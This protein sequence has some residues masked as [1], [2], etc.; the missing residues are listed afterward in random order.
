[1]GALRSL[2]RMI[3]F[4]LPFRQCKWYATIG[5]E[6]SDHICTQYAHAGMSWY[7]VQRYVYKLRV[8]MSS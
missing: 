3:R 1:M 5:L 7:F 8:Y 4:F 2:L 6:R